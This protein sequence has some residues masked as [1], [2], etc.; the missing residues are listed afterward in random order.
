MGTIDG[1]SGTAKFA[2]TVLRV[3]PAVG[4]CFYS[5]P[6]VLYD[7]T[8]GLMGVTASGVLS[9]DSVNGNRCYLDVIFR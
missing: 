6:I 9:K 5:G 4:F 1:R 7:G 2:S 8:V 3:N